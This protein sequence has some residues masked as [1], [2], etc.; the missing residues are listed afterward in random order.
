MEDGTYPARDM[1]PQ[2]EWGMKVSSHTESV[3][4]G[5]YTMRETHIPL[6]RI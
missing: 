3:R 2:A 6:G 5:I 1:R 4:H